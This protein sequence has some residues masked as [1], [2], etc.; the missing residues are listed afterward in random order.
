LMGIRKLTLICNFLALLAFSAI[1][2]YV[3]FI[4]VVEA[5]SRITELDRAGVIDEAKLRGGISEPC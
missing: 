1:L 2:A 3:A 4:G 5:P